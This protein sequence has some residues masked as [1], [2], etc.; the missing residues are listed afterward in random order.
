[1]KKLMIAAAIT[2]VA[3]VSQ[4]AEFK[5][6]TGSK[7]YLDNSDMSTWKD[8]DVLTALTSGTAGYMD[9]SKYSAITWAAQMTLSDGVSSDTIGITPNF[10][11][12]KI[13]TTG[14]SSSLFALP[15][16]D[17]TKEY[18]WSVV[19]TGTWM[20][21]EGNEWSIASN[22]I[23]GSGEFSKLS[24]AQ[25]NTGVPST[26]TVTGASVPEPTSGLLLLLGMAGLALRRRHA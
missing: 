5:W 21:S 19:F 18:S 13:N 4:A 25:I 3:V 8:G 15:A 1:M 2:F 6:T 20:D 9:A 26:W 7:L 16:D 17:S 11:S 22:P 14:V 10:S 24:A 12:H 23:A